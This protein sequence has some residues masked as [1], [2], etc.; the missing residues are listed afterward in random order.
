MMFLIRPLFRNLCRSLLDALPISASLCGMATSSR[1]ITS[2][3]RAALYVRVSTA[4]RGQTVENQLQPLYEAA[5]KLGW[6]VVAVF[7]DEGISGA[8]S[9]DKRP[10]LDGLLRGVA[11][12]QFDVVAAWSV[13]RLGR[14]LPDLIGLLG[15]L[16]A[17]SVDLYLHQ[18]ALDTSTPSGRMLF[19]MLSVFSEFERAMI[20]D[21][22]LAG[23]DRARASGKRLGRPRTTPFKIGRI[24]AALDEGKGVRET[25]RLLKVS[26]AKVSA[27]RRMTSSAGTVTVI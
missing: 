15:E 13:C 14:S 1:R 22:V 6:S 8:R 25:A 24:R 21:R 4:D 26:P 20:R 10:G 19:G 18:Q 27:I 9:R 7:K 17:R 3:K 11:R 12:R 16:Q 23:L 2:T 5:T